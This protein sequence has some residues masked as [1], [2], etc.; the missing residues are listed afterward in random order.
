[1]PGIGGRRLRLGQEREDAAAVVVHQH[2]R[3][4]QAVQARGD[5]RVEVVEERDVAD[6]QGDGAAGHRRGPERRRD[7]AVDAVGAAVRADGD[8]AVG[9]RE[10][11]V[12][13]A[14]R[15]G[16]AGPQDGAVG[17][18]V[19][20]R[21][22]TGRP[23]TARPAPASQAVHRLASPRR[24]AARQSAA[25]RRR[26]PGRR[27]AAR[28]ARS[29]RGGRV[30][31]DERRRAAARPRA[32]RRRRRGRAAPAG[33]APAA[34]AIGLD[35]G[36]APVRMTRS[37]QVGVEP[38][39]RA[40][41]LV[42]AGDDHATG[43]AARCAGRRA[44]RRGSGSRWRAASAASAA[45]SARVVVRAGDDQAALDRASRRAPARSSARVVERPAPGDDVARTGR[46]GRRVGGRRRQRPV[47]QQ[48]LAERDVDVDGPAGP[49]AAIATARPATQRQCASVAGSPSSSGSSVNHFARVRRGAPGRS[50]AA[51]RGPAA[52]P[53]GPP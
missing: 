20:Q 16:A 14:D 53:A 21:P 2:D 24:S 48:R 18:G 6:D 31:V 42:A 46:A 17:Q 1:M 43:R 28:R 37:G 19:G 11:G 33:S 32:S 4:R 29:A 10:P 38:G 47:G 45:G 51:R 44:G 9:G 36:M 52:P 8:R 23:R 7:D 34:R 49:A 50:S 35:V 30:R 3:G 13:V 26:R 22:A 40:A 5:Q 27:R 15:H 39:A 12:H 25:Q 41:E